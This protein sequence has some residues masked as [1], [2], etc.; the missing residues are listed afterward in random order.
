MF[1]VELNELRKHLVVLIGI[2]I[3]SGNNFRT[4]VSTDTL[5]MIEQNDAEL[6]GIYIGSGFPEDDIDDEDDGV[7]FG[8]FSSVSS[9][10]SARFS[11]CIAKNTNVTN[12]LVDLDN[13]GVDIT[14]CVIYNGLKQNTSIKL[15]EL[16]GFHYPIVG[17][18]G[19]Q[20]LNVYQENNTHLSGIKLIRCDIINGGDYLVA[21]TLSRCTYL[22]KVTLGIMH[23][24]DSQLLPLIEAIRDHR[25]L[26]ELELYGNSITNAGCQILATLLEDINS[27]LQYLNLYNNN[28]DSAGAKIIINSLSGN[29]QLRKLYLHGNRPMFDHNSL[30][31]QNVLDTLSQLLCKIS[32]INDT[33]LSNHTLQYLPEVD[34]RPL[35]KLN[36]GTNKHHVAIK[37]VLKCHRNIVMPPL[38]DL[39]KEGENNL[40]ALP[41]VV[42][43]FSKAEEAIADEDE[44]GSVWHESLGE[45][46]E[47][48][49]DDDSQGDYDLDARK[50]SAIYQFVQAMPLLFVPISHTKEDGKK[51]K[52]E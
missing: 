9:D 22:K 50:L 35:L 13:A 34:L 48:S 3:M 45:E 10:D 20:I 17:M 6:T 40:N 52:R 24:S 49:T 5:H 47:D 7:I 37:K 43:W 18:I 42:S 29:K 39:A 51:R 46:E 25:M 31:D 8:R 15:I 36:A 16:K 44:D 27:N 32:S 21:K 14:D 4:Y 11:S 28:I 19:Q 12:L 33:F 23:I 1:G 2:S 41:L 38:F 26:E 30:I